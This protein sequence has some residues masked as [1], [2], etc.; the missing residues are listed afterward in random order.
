MNILIAEDDED[1]RDALK[2]ALRVLGH[3]CR[4]AKDGVEAWEMHQA[5]LADVI[6][7]D[8]KMPR[9][10]GMELFR[11]VRAA[12]GPSS[13]AYLVLVTGGRG[14]SSSSKDEGIIDHYLVKPLDLAD[15]EACIAAAARAVLLRGPR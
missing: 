3:A 8:G 14:Q 2:A 12:E 15:L 7:S 4:V 13:R 9:M 11:K 10:D 6:I 5:L 1:S